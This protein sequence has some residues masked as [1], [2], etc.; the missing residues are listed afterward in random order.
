MAWWVPPSFGS[1]RS[2]VGSLRISFISITFD[3]RRSSSLLQNHTHH[4]LPMAIPRSTKPDESKTQMRSRVSRVM[5]FS[6]LVTEFLIVLTTFDRE[7]QL[8]KSL[9]FIPTI[10]SDLGRRSVNISPSSLLTGSAV[11]DAAQRTR[12]SFKSCWNMRGSESRVSDCREVRT[13]ILLWEALVSRPNN[14][15]RMS[16]APRMPV[17][18]SKCKCDRNKSARSA[19]RYIEFLNQFSPI[20]SRR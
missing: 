10:G 12:M 4:Y 3:A 5:L 11:G 20:T 8:R 16:K 1:I 19:G 15:R 9:A 6:M 2:I 17:M 14:G 18:G 7:E 13:S